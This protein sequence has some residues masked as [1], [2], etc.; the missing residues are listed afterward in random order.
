[1]RRGRAL[2]LLGWLFAAAIAVLTT[3]DT[4]ACR[5][6]DSDDCGLPPSPIG[7]WPSPWPLW[8]GAGIV[9]LAVI[10]LVATWIRTR[11]TPE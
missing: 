3:G 9:A 4:V 6:T 8:V 7:P 5:L 1:M 2:A 10:G 11:R